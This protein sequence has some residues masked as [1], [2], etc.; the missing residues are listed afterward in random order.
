MVY[1]SIAKNIIKLGE[2]S[3][4]GKSTATLS[5]GYP[6]FVAVIY[7]ALGAGDFWIR[8][9]Q[10]ILEIF[11]GFFFFLISMNFFKAKWSVISLAIFTFLPSNLIYSQTVL[12]EPLFGLLAIIILYYFLK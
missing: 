7:K 12:T 11:T 3:F 6:L 8:I 10:S 9:V 5:C 2:Y 4:E 1:E